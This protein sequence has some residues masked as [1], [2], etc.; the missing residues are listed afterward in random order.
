MNER[1]KHARQRRL[2][3]AEIFFD[4]AR[5]PVSCLIRDISPSGAQLF[6]DPIRGVPSEFRLAISGRRGFNCFV[7]WRDSIRMGVEFLQPHSVR[8]G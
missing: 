6:V 8:I 5:Q 2:Q 1:R 3:R 4:G 7:K